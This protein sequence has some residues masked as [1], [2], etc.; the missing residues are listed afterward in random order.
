MLRQG[1]VDKN[2][3]QPCQ[4]CDTLKKPCPPPKILSQ[5]HESKSR[6]I[7]AKTR[8]CFAEHPS[9]VHF[10]LV[11]IPFQ[12]LFSKDP[13]AQHL[14]TCPTPLMSQKFSNSTGTPL[15]SIFLY[16]S[17]TWSHNPASQAPGLGSFR[18]NV[19]VSQVNVLQSLVDF[20][21]FGKGLWTKNGGQPCESW[22]LA[23][24][25]AVTNEWIST[26]SWS[27]HHRDI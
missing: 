21:C 13:L 18:A 1:P 2:G 14:N 16:H 3:G 23:T 17:E 9:P 7:S 5:D 27:N 26:S 4:I 15:D 19:I 24:L 6:W 12:W 25:S 11:S 22:E 10:Y 20:E 8:L